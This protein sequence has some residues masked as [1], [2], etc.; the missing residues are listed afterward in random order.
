ML[1][2]ETG[3]PPAPG[4]QAAAPPHSSRVML[5]VRNWFSILVDFTFVVSFM[6][7]FILISFQKSL[8]L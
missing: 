6:I 2:V 4:H 5:C 8:Y 3:S 7:A 1:V